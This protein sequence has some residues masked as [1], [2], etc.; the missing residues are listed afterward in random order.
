M[1]DV[2][3]RQFK[4]DDGLVLLFVLH[5]CVGFDI[6]LPRGDEASKRKA[7]RID[8]TDTYRRTCLF[9]MYVY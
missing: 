1:F 7:S 8:G 6:F 4:S 5:S 2:D 9:S 3:T